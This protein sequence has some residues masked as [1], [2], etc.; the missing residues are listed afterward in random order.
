MRV[1]PEA[2][3]APSIARPRAPAPSRR[4]RSGAIAFSS[5][6]KQEQILAV[7]AETWLPDLATSAGGPTVWGH[8][9]LAFGRRLTAPDGAQISPPAVSD[10][11][12]FRDP[13]FHG[14][15]QLGQSVC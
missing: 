4:A 5:P 8:R 7:L 13:R 15:T 2:T 14:A 11:P 12:G 9:Y 6:K 3:R 1:S 10:A